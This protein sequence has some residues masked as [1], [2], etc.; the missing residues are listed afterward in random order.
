MPLFNTAAWLVGHLDLLFHFITPHV[1]VSFTGIS[2]GYLPLAVLSAL[3]LGKEGITAS[4][5]SIR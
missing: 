4:P 3:S 5:I 1:Q 2:L